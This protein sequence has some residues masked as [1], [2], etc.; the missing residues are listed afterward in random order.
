MKL[1]FWILLI[2]SKVAFAQLELVPLELSKTVRPGEVSDVQILTKEENLIVNYPPKKLQLFG[3]ADSFFVYSLGPWVK[4]KDG[5]GITGKIVFG[6]SFSPDKIYSYPGD[7]GSVQFQFKGWLW[8]PSAEATTEEFSYEEI[9]LFSRSW[10]IKNWPISI[11]VL[12]LVLGTIFRAMYV[13]LAA[14]K[15][16]LAE[17]NK[18]MQLKDEILQA[19]SIHEFGMLWTKRDEM[20]RIFSKHELSFRIFFD[21]LNRYQFKPKVSDTELAQICVAKSKLLAELSEDKHGV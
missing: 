21:E 12:V 5:W 2:F 10:W 6:K 17:K 7:L 14:R 3:D 1:L 15:I 20:K 13:F 8:N 19:Q 16:T 18:R 4:N 9:P 11:F